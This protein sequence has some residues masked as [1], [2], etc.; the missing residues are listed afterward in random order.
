MDA[1]YAYLFR[2]GSDQEELL[3][4][5]ICYRRDPPFCSNF[6][7]SSCW[8]T[9]LKTGT[10]PSRAI[11]YHSRMYDMEVRA[12]PKEY[13]NTKLL[14]EGQKTIKFNSS[15][16]LILSFHSVVER[17]KETYNYVLQKNRKGE[18][19]YKIKKNSD[20]SR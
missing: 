4:K 19:G 16:Q 12:F 2:H 7:V 3:G 9:R 17:L 13:S 1:S 18:L 6:K 5:K 8:K 14:H 11:V 20:E 10:I 15:I